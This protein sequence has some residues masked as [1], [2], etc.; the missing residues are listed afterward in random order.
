LILTFPLVYLKAGTMTGF[1]IVA[2]GVIFF[3]NT[4][5]VSADFILCLI[6]EMMHFLKREAV[7]GMT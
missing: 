3:R 4:A 5:M 7:N 6:P 2:C 1:T